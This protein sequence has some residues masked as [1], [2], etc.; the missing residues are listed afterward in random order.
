MKRA[1]VLTLALLAGLT[2][3]IGMGVAQAASE[4]PGDPCAVPES[5]YTVDGALPRAWER[6][7]RGGA[8]PILVLNSA[9]SRPDTAY[10]V[11]LEKELAARLPDRKVSV[12][13]RNAP[14]ATAQEMLP[15]LNREL[16]A[17][18]ASLLVWQVGTADAMRNIGPDS[19]GEA[20]GRGIAAAQGRGADVIL[21]D[22]QYSPQTAQLI[23]F[24]PYLDYMEW[25]SQDSDVVHFPRFEMMRH[26]FEDGRVGFSPDSKEEKLQAYQFV[27]RCLGRIL[28]DTVSTMIDRA[29]RPA[30]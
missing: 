8:L 22:M 21:M 30:P 15:I 5:V 29:G 27:H 23:T 18:S 12:T 2:V 25:V 11:L 14:G 13:V 24:Q 7:K 20:L 6:L 1:T 16:A 4:T 9:S 10:P 28:A 26:W 17:S 19:F 3:S